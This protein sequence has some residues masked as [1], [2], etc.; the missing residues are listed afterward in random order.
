MIV[1][2]LLVVG[3][4]LVDQFTKKYARKKLLFRQ[5]K[6]GP[7]TFKLVYN[8][9]A[10]RGLLKKRPVILILI[11]VT[12]VV[13]LGVLW[14]IYGFFKKERSITLALSMILGGAIGNLIDRI[15]E[16]QVT[17]FFAITWTKKLFYNMADWFIFI[18]G[19]WLVILEIKAYVTKS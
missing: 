4:V 18:G 15:S 19:F 1:A 10:F 8:K 13:F 9:G 6:K 16:G 11:Q 17:D 7:L 14:V 12:A 2:I 3:L 5:C